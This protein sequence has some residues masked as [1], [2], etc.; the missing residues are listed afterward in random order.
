ML[1]IYKTGIGSLWHPAVID[2]IEDG[3]LHLQ[4]LYSVRQLS[5]PNDGI[6]ES[7]RFLPDST[8]ICPIGLYPAYINVTLGNVG[9]RGKLTKNA[10]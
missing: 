3:Y 10:F 4:D 6:P 5:K 8:D 1:L 9:L 7:I 2:S